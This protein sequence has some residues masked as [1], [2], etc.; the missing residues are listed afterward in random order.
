MIQFPNK[1]CPEWSFIFMGQRSLS[2][3]VVRVNHSVPYF[4]KGALDQESQD[5]L[6]LVSFLILCIG[7]KSYP[8]HLPKA[9]KDK[10]LKSCTIKT[11]DIL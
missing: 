1:K 5:P 4:L 9:K 6:E 2:T 3:A 11:K 7:S 10:F 8:V